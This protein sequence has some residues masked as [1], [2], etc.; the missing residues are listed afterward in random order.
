[1]DYKEIKTILLEKHKDSKFSNY[2]SIFFRIKKIC[3]IRIN[4]MKVKTQKHYTQF[5]L[6]FI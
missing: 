2:S 3:F 4:E 6:D 5:E 1:M